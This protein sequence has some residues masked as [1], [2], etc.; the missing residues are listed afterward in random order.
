MFQDPD[1]S[2]V[3]EKVLVFLPVIRLINI[4]G[5]FLWG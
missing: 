2:P 5:F 1:V 3:S 4:Q